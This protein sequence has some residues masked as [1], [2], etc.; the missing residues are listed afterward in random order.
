MNDTFIT[1]QRRRKEIWEG[2]T[3][4]GLDDGSPQ[5]VPRGGAPVEGLGDEDPR[6]WR[7]LRIFGS[8]S[9]FPPIYAYIFRACRHHSTK[10]AK[11]G[12]EHL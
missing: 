7:I 11:W 9:H 5:A 2:G 8:I 4:G 10:S 12:G 6:S 3:T 1:L